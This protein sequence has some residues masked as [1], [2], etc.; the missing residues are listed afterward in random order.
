MKPWTVLPKSPPDSPSVLSPHP[1]LFSPH[2]SPHTDIV[3]TLKS[4]ENPAVQERI[5]ATIFHP[6]R[7]P[8]Q[9]LNSSGLPLHDEVAAPSLTGTRERVL[10]LVQGVLERHGAVQS[11]SS[12]LELVDLC[13]PGDHRSTP[14]KSTQDS[15]LTFLSPSPSPQGLHQSG[16][17]IWTRSALEAQRQAVTRQVAGSQPDLFPEAVRVVPGVPQPSGP[18]SPPR[19]LPG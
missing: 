10:R 14:H 3:R 1:P 4:G 11:E 8:E 6:E 19:V 16:G 15:Q 13:S 18:K 9:G 2:Y 5:L 17:R 12:T 7:S